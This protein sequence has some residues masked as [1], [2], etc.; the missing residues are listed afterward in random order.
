[1]TPRA[2]QVL[3]YTASIYRAAGVAVALYTL[4][5][6]AYVLVWMPR[7]RLHNFGI[8]MAGAYTIALV[9]ALALIGSGL[10]LC[11]AYALRREA[12]P[13]AVLYVLVLA[14]VLLLCDFLL[15]PPIVG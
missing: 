11:G 6:Y 3:K 2:E 8:A 9:G 15:L 5:L 10:L 12:P 7:G 13:N 14:I 4:G 1:M